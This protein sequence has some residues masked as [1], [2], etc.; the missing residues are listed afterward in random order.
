M[1][2]SSAIT[3]PYHQCKEWNKENVKM[4]NSRSRSRTTRSRTR[5]DK[6]WDWDT[7]KGRSYPIVFDFVKPLTHEK[8]CIQIIRL[9]KTSDT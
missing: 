9:C 4:R 8:H 3:L 1:Q 2:M 7:S 6:D 5:E